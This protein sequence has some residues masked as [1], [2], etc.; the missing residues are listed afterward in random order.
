MVELCD[1]HAQPFDFRLKLRGAHR[2]DRTRLGRDD[3]LHRCPVEAAQKLLGAAHFRPWSRISRKAVEQQRFHLFAVPRLPL[4]SGSHLSRRALTRPRQTEIVA[5]FSFPGAFSWTALVSS[6]RSPMPTLSCTY[7]LDPPYPGGE[8]FGMA[9]MPHG[10][11]NRLAM[12][13][14]SLLD[15]STNG[16][17]HATPSL[18]PPRTRTSICPAKGSSSRMRT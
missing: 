1:A 16:Y 12:K 10:A 6:R 9:T 14:P 13:F 3:L 4:K 15:L 11:E 7:R 17:Q 8:V 18:T 2:Q 5:Q